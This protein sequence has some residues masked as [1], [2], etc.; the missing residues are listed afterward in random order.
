[1]GHKDAKSDSQSVAQVDGQV[2]S[3]RLSGCGH[4]SNSAASKQLWRQEEEEEVREDDKA[5]SMTLK[6]LLVV[7]LI[8]TIWL[9]LM[10]NL[11]ILLK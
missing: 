3:H 9:W 2:L 8:F 1:M 11:I 4:L 6:V 5:Q 7:L 10:N